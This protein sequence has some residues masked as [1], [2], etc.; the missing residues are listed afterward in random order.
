MTHLDYSLEVFLANTFHIDRMI[1][2]AVRDPKIH[3]LPI[4]CPWPPAAGN[5]LR[6]LK[7]YMFFVICT[8]FAFKAATE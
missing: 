6:L 7:I 3:S 8:M 5:K 4:V 2:G 1:K